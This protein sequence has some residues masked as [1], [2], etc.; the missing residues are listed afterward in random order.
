MANT[1]S[2]YFFLPLYRMTDKILNP[3]T[4]RRIKLGSAAH[5]KLME[6]GVVPNIINGTEK[7]IPSE[8]CDSKVSN[9]TPMPTEVKVSENGKTKMSATLESLDS[10]ITITVGEYQIKIKRKS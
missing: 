8:V 4:N 7:V 6:S 10:G 2:V 3:N 1:P 5:I 9:E